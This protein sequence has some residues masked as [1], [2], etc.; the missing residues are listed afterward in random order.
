VRTLRELLEDYLAMRRGLG[1]KLT[2]DGAALASFV[3]F[4]EQVPAEAI[5]TDLAL[6]WAKQPTQVPPARWAARLRFVRGFARYCSAIDPRT[7]VPPAALLPFAYRRPSPYFYTDDDL[8]RLLQGALQWPAPQGLANRTYYCL[9]GLLGVSGLR[10]GEALRLS[11]DDVDLDAGLLTIRATKFGKN[12][13]VPLHPSTVAVLSD[14]HQRR[15]QF[16]T[17]RQVAPWF[18]DV[19]GEPLGYD[20]VR[21]VFRALTAELPNQPGRA[22]PRLHDLRHRFALTTLVQWY[23]TGQDVPR[24]LPVLSAFLGHTEVGNTYWYLSACPALLEAAT[25]RLERHWEQTV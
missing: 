9:F 24:R 23:R 7:E 5:T 25:A 16:L 1:F 6:A 14:Y 12:R 22:R 8:N 13:L 17:G 18:V 10:I 2:S 19:R 21:R 11:L 15:T 3:R 4:M 20:E